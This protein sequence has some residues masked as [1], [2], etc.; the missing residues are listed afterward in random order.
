M[1]FDLFL[2]SLWQNAIFSTLLGSQPLLCRVASDLD[3]M[4]LFIFHWCFTGVA[5]GSLTWNKQF[6][7]AALEKR[8]A[9]IVWCLAYSALCGQG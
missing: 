1:L 2:L 3:Q 7:A 9:K 5:P 4:S 6:A 8:S